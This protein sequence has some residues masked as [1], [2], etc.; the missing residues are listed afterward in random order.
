MTVAQLAK[1]VGKELPLSRVQELLYPAGDARL[2]DA[3]KKL[4][5]SPEYRLEEI[6]GSGGSPLI[7]P[8][9]QLSG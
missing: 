5:N 3:K 2:E 9:Q 1:I 6:G 4:A 8:L 7:F